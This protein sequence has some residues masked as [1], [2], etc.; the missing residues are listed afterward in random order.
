MNSICTIKSNMT[1]AQLVLDIT[2]CVSA[3]LATDTYQKLLEK[4]ASITDKIIFND[5]I[6]V[7][8]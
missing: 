8:C 3:K 5:V 4:N 7:T 6:F 1:D 2:L